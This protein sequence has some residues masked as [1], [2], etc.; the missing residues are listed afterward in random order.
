[1]TNDL[2]RLLVQLMDMRDKWIAKQPNTE[3][4]TDK[5]AQGIEQGIEMCIQKV[6]EMANGKAD[7]ENT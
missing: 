4:I 7:G 5:R 1:M 3:W 2:N 6:R